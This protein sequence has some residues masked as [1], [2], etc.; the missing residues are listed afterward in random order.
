MRDQVLRLGF[1]F[2]VFCTA[3]VAGFLFQG[4]VRSGSDATPVQAQPV[5]NVLVL[6]VDGTLD[7]YPFPFNPDL[8]QRQGD[9][10]L[11][12]GFANGIFYD[13]FP[14]PLEEGDRFIGIDP[15]SRTDLPASSVPTPTIA[16]AV[17]LDSPAK[18]PRDV[19]PPVIPPCTPV[20][21]QRGPEPCP[22]SAQ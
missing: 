2:V 22:L 15:P 6:R 13:F 20:V 4:E 7:A 18:A 21:D 11:V 14:I 10:L 12:S 16:P 9:S 8:V 19:P 3:S 1:V 5:Y 17:E